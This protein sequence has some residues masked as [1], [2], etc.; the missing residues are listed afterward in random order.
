MP[1]LKS[2][3]SKNQRTVFFTR[4]LLI[5]ILREKEKSLCMAQSSTKR[6][7]CFNARKFKLNYDC[8]CCC[9]VPWNHFH[10]KRPFKLIHFTW[11]WMEWIMT[12]QSTNE[13][14]VNKQ[15]SRTQ[16]SQRQRRDVLVVFSDK[17]WWSSLHSPHSHNHQ[18][19]EEG[20]EREPRFSRDPGIYSQSRKFPEA[21]IKNS[22]K[23]S[24][25]F[26]IQ[27]IKCFVLVWDFPLENFDD[28]KTF[29]QEL[30]FFF[31]TPGISKVLFD[32]EIQGMNGNSQSIKFYFECFVYTRFTRS[33]RPLVFRFDTKLCVL[34][35]IFFAARFQYKVWWLVTS[36]YFE[37]L[38]FSLILTNTITLAMRVSSAG[39]GRS[40][41]SGPEC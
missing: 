6:N 21:I 17:W 31:E 33:Q 3:K 13:P 24:W 19:R 8:C 27:K 16:S 29:F 9:V 30:W 28:W 32:A 12:V 14:T 7:A 1:R 34:F 39:E 40:M 18:A 2:R 41:I 38:I 36:H 20:E 25:F 10:L 5:S 35:F 22:I 11:P 26:P 15:E 37:Y 23:T 4:I